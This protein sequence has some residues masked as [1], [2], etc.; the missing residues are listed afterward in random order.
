M[1]P[2]RTR[3]PKLQRT[4]PLDTPEN[5]PEPLQT[6]DENEQA[7]EKALFP[8]LDLQAER[9][10]AVTKAF[11]KRL[12]E[13]QI[14]IAELIPADK[15]E[16]VRLAITETHAREQ[17][18]VIDFLTKHDAP[19]PIKS[20]GYILSLTAALTRTQRTERK[21]VYHALRGIKRD[22]KKKAFAR[23]RDAQETTRALIKK[24]ISKRVGTTQIILMQDWTG[25]GKSTTG[26][27]LLF[28]LE[29]KTIALSPTLELAVQAERD[30]K[31]DGFLNPRTI[32]GRG[33][34]WEQ[35]GIE[36]IP[37]AMRDETLFDK[38]HCVFVNEVE[39]YTKDNLPARA[40]CEKECP[41]R[42]ECKK[43]GY[44]A[45]FHDVDTVDFL[46][47]AMPTL[48]FN[49]IMHGFLA[50]L[51]TG[52]NAAIP[53]ADDLYGITLDTANSTTQGETP[54]EVDATQRKTAFDTAQIED[55]EVDTLYNACTIRQ[56]RIKA[57]RNAWQNDKGKHTASL[58]ADAILDAFKET[59]RETCFQVLRKVVE[60]F[61]ATE[62]ETE[63]LNI[64]LSHHAR[65]GVI[66][67]NPTDIR[68]ENGRIISTHRVEFD[69]GQ[70]LA[71]I[72][73]PE[74]E[75]HAVNVLREQKKPFVERRHIPP[76]TRVG[77]PI[78][79]P[80]HF[81]DAL[82]SYD[83][84]ELSPLWSKNWTLL[85]QLIALI[86]SVGAPANAPLRLA[87]GYIEFDAPPQVNGLLK[88]IIMLSPVDHSEQITRALIGQN[89]TIESITAEKC[90]LASGVKIYQYNEHR[91]T[92][93]SVF[94]R[95]KNEQGKTLH[96][97]KPT[98]IRP[99]HAARIDKLNAFA[100]D[101]DGITLFVSYK[102]FQTQFPEVV[103][104]FDYV[105]NFDE[106]AGLNIEGLKLL[107]IYGLPK[108]NHE[109]VMTV[110]LKQHASDTEPIPT[111]DPNLT[112]ANGKPISEYVQL[113]T[114]QVWHDSD[115]LAITERRYTDP[116]LYAVWQQLTLDKLNQTVGRAR[117]IRWTD[118]ETLIFTNAKIANTTDRPEVV[119]FTS[120]AF[121]A[122]EC[123]SDIP[124]AEQRLTQA[125]KAGDI[126]AIM[127]QQGV[128]Q[129]T[130]YR[131]TKNATAKKAADRKTRNADII[132]RAAAGE[133]QKDLAVAFGLTQQAVSKIISDAARDQ[134]T[135][136]C[137]RQLSTLI[138]N[139]KELY[140]REN[141]CHPCVD[142][143]SPP[144]PPR[145]ADT[146]SNLQNDHSAQQ[147]DHSE[148]PRDT[149]V[150]ELHREGKS[151]R[152][153]TQTLKDEGYT[154]VSKTTV[155]KVID[156]WKNTRNTR[157]KA[158]AA[159]RYTPK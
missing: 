129:R 25:A 10:G 153:I 83:R 147:S 12:V 54:P 61:T 13:I 156:A 89:V 149:R 2:Q 148:T 28:K 65:H 57:L 159:V 30:A 100:R 110:T 36:V 59:D 49:P 88:T 71:Y 4:A 133:T 85:H 155:K 145:L 93:Q 69:N 142:A 73:T 3:A 135:T 41:Y 138:G 139:G 107:V 119:F 46:S 117:H 154:A 111:G 143:R 24:E 51:A 158:A 146:P 63:T 115:G 144:A 78:I 97:C 122:A 34:D 105:K 95:P 116:R 106:V 44:L 99:T 137:Q 132:R 76:E 84:T 6:L 131:K 8:L 103:K 128:S 141:P 81:W 114:E 50:Y 18:A 91:V 120:A 74:N 16:R 53:D 98:G 42:D 56:E 7:R 136:N 9:T 20:D 109:T 35:S 90:E 66:A 47:Y 134:N 52:E 45:Q 43:S 11:D 92:S 23:Y 31:K 48:P 150:I 104:D 15:R 67:E 121:D 70:S 75:E 87:D 140:N 27:T 26:R 124:A 38:N 94:E 14:A 118:T 86:E 40:F 37:T 19:P 33:A 58:F 102:E 125:E 79:V 55:F 5:E 21:S 82:N 17:A 39:F 112:D 157:R 126:D 60:V 113:T 64:E 108:I 77:D 22:A 151:Q 80:T 101:T 123:I 1:P 29:N 62:T 127:A 152:A 68:D 72:P 130:A 96:Q 32:R